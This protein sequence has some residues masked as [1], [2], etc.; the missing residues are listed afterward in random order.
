MQKFVNQRRAIASGSR[1]CKAAFPA[2][3]DTCLLM[4]GL[5]DQLVVSLVLGLLDQLVVGLYPGAFWGLLA[6][7]AVGCSIVICSCLVVCLWCIS[8]Q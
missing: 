7:V 3:G 8:D 4:L 1:L 5:L 6:G 2:A